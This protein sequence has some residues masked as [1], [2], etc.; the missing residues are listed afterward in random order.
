MQLCDRIVL[1]Y[2][3]TVRSVLENGNGIDSDRIMALVAG[4]GVGA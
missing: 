4:G 2:E 1:M 3:G